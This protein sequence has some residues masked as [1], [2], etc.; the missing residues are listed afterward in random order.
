MRKSRSNARLII[1]LPAVLGICRG[2]ALADA[3]QFTVAAAQYVFN[4]HSQ[5][6]T[7]DAQSEI[8]PP[9][10][11]CYSTYPPASHT[12]AHHGH[13]TQ[14]PT[15]GAYVWMMDGGARDGGFEERRGDTLTTFAAQGPQGGTHLLRKTSIEPPAYASYHWELF[16]TLYDPSRGK[17]YAFANV[18]DSGYLP[19][20]TQNMLFVGESAN[21]VDN[22]TWT[23]VYENRRPTTDRLFFNHDHYILDPSDPGRWIGFLGWG[24]F[25][26]LAGVAPAYIDMDRLKF[27]VL[28]QSEG[29][30]EYP[31]GHVFDSF[32]PNAT[33]ASQ[34]S[35]LPDLP[36]QIPELSKFTIRALALVNGKAIVL[37][38]EWTSQACLDTD[39]ACIQS[40]TPC[41]PG[42]DWT[43][44]K[45]RRNYSNW[46]FGSRLSVRE[47]SLASW[48]TTLTAAQWTGPA[49]VI[50]DGTQAGP[51]KINPSDIG[52]GSYDAA[53][54]Q[55]ADGRVYLYLS[56][57]HS[58]CLPASNPSLN[59]WNRPPDGS[60]GT[61]MM[62]FRLTYIP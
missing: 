57:K 7:C 45:T 31:L 17:F 12:F 30:C 59:Q 47:L 2:T 21:G 6:W 11:N 43:L 1:I 55:H 27:G 51:F 41:P 16:S 22:F 26:A 35:A 61:S 37:N 32:D 50:L 8:N 10:T 15:T 58:L 56:I 18:T 28:F 62:W 20:V 54:K 23:K 60:S 49:K 3:P 25:G 24:D 4:S 5:N 34:G 42:Q 48:N 38:H 9:T 29:W 44:Y 52:V 13:I 33:C 46:D 53:L 36:Y 39:D 19:E 40:R 14:N